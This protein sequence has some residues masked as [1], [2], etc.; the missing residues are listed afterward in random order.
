M[1]TADALG[2]ALTNAVEQF[3]HLASKTMA[4]SLKAVEEEVSPY[5]PQPNRMRSGHMN[6]YVRGQG[7]YPK[8]A[9]VPDA[10]A[11]GGFATK[12]VK[13]GVVRFT[14]QQMDKRYHMSVT[15]AGQSIEG[16]L[17]N[18]ATYSG[19]VIGSKT[20]DPRQQSFHAETGWPNKEDSFEAAKPKINSFVEAV[21]DEFMLAV[22]GV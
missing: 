10:S 18:S 7:S 20:D 9:F 13:T 2:R 17:W 6:T 15:D 22:K 16:R 3:K 1:S 14:S 19:Y 8:S 11:P 5:P 12:R 21:I 4:L